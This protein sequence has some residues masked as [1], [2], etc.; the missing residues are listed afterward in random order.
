[1]NCYAS[2]VIAVN[3]YSPMLLSKPNLL[4]KHWKPVLRLV[5]PGTVSRQF[6]TYVRVHFLKL[7]RNPEFIYIGTDPAPAYLW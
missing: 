7:L 2:Q 3:T 6:P 4:F 1:M 5:G